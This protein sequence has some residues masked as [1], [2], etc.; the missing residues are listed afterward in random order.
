MGIGKSHIHV[1]RLCAVAMAWIYQIT[2]ETQ[3]GD[4]ATGI[5]EWIQIFLFGFSRLR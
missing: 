4:I 2:H 1:F 3:D 5:Q